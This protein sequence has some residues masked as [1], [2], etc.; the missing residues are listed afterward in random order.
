MSHVRDRRSWIE[1]L[2]AVN[3]LPFVLGLLAL[4]LAIL[5]VVLLGWGGWRWD[6]AVMGLGSLLLGLGMV[7]LYFW[8]HRSD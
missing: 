1:G 2:R 3:R 4:F 5:S 8:H 6:L 7:G